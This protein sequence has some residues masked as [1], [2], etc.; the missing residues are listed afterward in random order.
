MG[1][2]KY[3]ILCTHHDSIIQDC[4]PILKVHCAPPTWHSPLSSETLATTDLFTISTVLHFPK[5]SCSWN[6]TVVPFQTSFFHLAICMCCSSVSLGGLTT[7]FLLFLNNSPLYGC[8]SLFIS[9]Y[10]MKGHLGGFQFLSIMNKALIN[11]LFKVLSG[12][13]RLLFL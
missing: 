11:L 12:S 4:S 8:S 6:H 10:P 13:W 5:P 3:I 9:L 7:H 2:D 1:L